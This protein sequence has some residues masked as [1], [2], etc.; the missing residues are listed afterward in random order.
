[1]KDILKQAL[2]NQYIHSSDL[3]QTIKKMCEKQNVHVKHVQANIHELTVSIQT[4]KETFKLPYFKFNKLNQT[5][6]F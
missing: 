3:Y 2:T 1:M 4:N 5:F 6:K